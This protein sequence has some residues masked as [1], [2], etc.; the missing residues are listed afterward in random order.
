[1]RVF[2]R[3][4]TILLN[5][6]LFLFSLSAV[7]KKRKTPEGYPT[8]EAIAS[9]TQSDAVTSMHSTK[10]PGISS[11][12][13]AKDG[14]LLLTGGMDKNLIVH[15]R[16]SNKTLATCK[17]HTKKITAAAFVSA[18]PEDASALPE[19]LASASLDNKIRLWTVNPD[20][21]VGKKK[22]EAYIAAGVISTHK[23]EVTGLKV[24]PTRSLIATTSA[25]GTWALHDVADPA[26]P[27]TV[28]HVS[29]PASDVQATSLAIHPDGMI[30]AVGASDSSLYV[31]NATK[32]A[33]AAELNGHKQN[34]G[35]AINSLDF[36]ENG[37]IL[38]SS[39]SAPGSAVNIWD[40]RK[41][42]QSAT[43]PAP[44]AEAKIEAVKFDHS[45]QYLATVGSSLNVWAWKS[46]DK[47]LLTFEDNTADLTG[48]AFAQHDKEIIVGGMDRTVR[49]I[50]APAA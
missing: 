34:G 46:W 40:L 10:P 22:H 44:S 37:Y 45:A 33:L 48:V 7:R 15:D 24:H 19:V 38:A 2:Q 31:F 27:K 28:L 5:S 20:P 16:S 17:G 1:M 29:L 4:L 43:Y 35:G 3:T 23:G 21:P 50:S 25:D 13:V 8:N 49:V 11:L 14:S 41:Q 26:E 18:D 47:P 36:S 42:K 9:Y 12:A 32:G 6:Q 30:L 39:T